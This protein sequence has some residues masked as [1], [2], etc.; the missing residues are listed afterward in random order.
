[1][2]THVKLKSGRASL[3][4]ACGLTAVIILPLLPIG[5]WIV[6]GESI[7][8]LLGREAV[9]WIY[10][11][12]VLIWLVIV[13]R[14]PLATIGIRR[15]GWKTLLF[16]VLGATAVLFL[17]ILHMGVIVRI[18]HLDTTVALAQQRMILSRPYWFRVLLVLR[19]A[20]V[21]E[22]L[23]RGYMIEKVRQLTGS[24]VLAIGVSVLTFTL[25][26]YAGWGLVQLIP[27]FGAG[28]VL[29]LLYTWRRDLP[30]NMLAH[31]LTDGA[32]F[33]LR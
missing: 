11:A 14:L 3:L 28:V 18:F 4:A 8:A 27:V 5:R 19:G 10:A 29:A 2:T 13:E 12:A 33:L 16:A 6:P 24:A 20:V 7:S 9:W 17:M 30:S 1:M 23:F 26:H 31:F 15:P 21:E 32:G 25:A 22:I